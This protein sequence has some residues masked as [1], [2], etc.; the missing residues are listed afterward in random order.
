MTNCEKNRERYKK[1]FDVLAAS[2]KISLEVDQM[3]NKKQTS[4]YKKSVAAAVAAL[5]FVMAAGSGVY[6]AARHWGILD[7][8]ERTA[9]DVPEEAVPQIQS[10]MHVEQM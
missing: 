3:K 2:E 8:A 9:M 1:A 7:F 6:A 10:A 4:N 5:V